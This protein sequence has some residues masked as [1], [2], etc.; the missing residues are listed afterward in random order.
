MNG[1]GSLCLSCLRLISFYHP[2]H[3][4]RHIADLLE[5]LWKHLLF[6]RIR[7]FQLMEWVQI[8][9]HVSSRK[10]VHQVSW[11]QLWQLH[12]VIFI[13]LVIVRCLILLFIDILGKGYDVYLSYLLTISVVTFWNL[14]KFGCLCTSNLHQ[15][16]DIS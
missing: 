16:H 3:S 11:R 2:L 12:Q 6:I 4:M 10:Q 1:S 15:L 14:A 7:Q 5:A 8:F 13:F 9:V